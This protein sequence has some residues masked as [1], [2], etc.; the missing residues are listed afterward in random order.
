MNYFWVTTH[1][2][3]NTV[4]NHTQTTL[5]KQK[6]PPPLGPRFR[7]SKSRVCHKVMTTIY[8]AAV[9]HSD[10]AEDWRRKTADAAEGSPAKTRQ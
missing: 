8:Q 5:E 7:K 4:F 3:L 1:H 10:I 6:H 9:L 2:L